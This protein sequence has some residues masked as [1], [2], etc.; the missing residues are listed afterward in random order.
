V[1]PSSSLAAMG[2]GRGRSILLR[3][4]ERRGG[5]REGTEIEGRSQG[6]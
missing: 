4:M 5:R 3:G 1:L 2:E 6:K